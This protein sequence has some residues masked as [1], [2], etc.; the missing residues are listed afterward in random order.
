MPTAYA[1]LSK[2]PRFKDLTGSVFMRWTVLGYLGKIKGLHHWECRCSCGTTSAVF[3]GN[4]TSN[5]SRGCNECRP[6]PEGRPRKSKRLDFMSEYGSWSN[7][8]RRCTNPKD[9]AFP[10][11]GGRGIKVC[12]SWLASFD[13]FLADM[14]PKPEAG[15]EID[16]IDVNG[17]YE[18]SNCRWATSKEQNRNKRNNRYFTINNQ[19]RCLAEW[20]EMHSIGIGT[21]KTRLKHGWSIE[22]ALRTPPRFNKLHHG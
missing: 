13:A 2:D 1:P 15:L 16:R 18:P 14:G 6:S 3:G 9:D 22:R 7:M 17:D 19:K 4:L 10:A 5:K 8:V 21:V 12:R 20:C 11:Y